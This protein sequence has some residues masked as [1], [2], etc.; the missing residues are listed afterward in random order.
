MLQAEELIKQEMITMLHYDAIQNGDPPMPNSFHK[1]SSINL[2]AQHLA[3]LE[4]H[5][6]ENIEEEELE[7]VGISRFLKLVRAELLV[8]LF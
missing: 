2:H 6:Y 4:E 7:K 1:K 8:R 3:H 5:P